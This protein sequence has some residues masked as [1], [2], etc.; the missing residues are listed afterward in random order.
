[1]SRYAAYIDESGNHDLVTEKNGASRYFIVL[2]ILVEETSLAELTTAVTAIKHEFFGPGEMK[3]SRVREDRRVRVLDALAPLPFRFYAVAVDKARIDRDSGLAFKTSFIKFANG[4]LYNAL[5]QNLTDLT[6]YADGH[7][8]AEFIE[9]FKKYL[10]TAHTPDLFSRPKIEIVDSRQEVLVQLADFL[11]GTAAKIYENKA[12]A[13]ARK[14]FLD[15]LGR[16]RIRIDEWPPRF[17][18]QYPAV[19]G[20]SDLDGQVRSIS[21]RAAAQFLSDFSDVEDLE[22]RIQHAFVSYL[23]FRAQFPLEEEFMSTPELIDHLGSLG[24]EEIDKHFLR[25]NV[26]S[27]LRDRGVLI[28]SSARGYKVPTTYSDVIGFAELVDGIVSPLLHRLRR[29]ND[30][31]SL[32]SGGAID[33]LGDVRFRKLRQILELDVRDERP[34]A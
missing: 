9:S 31:L 6:V 18:S 8:G 26:V 10:E 30:L 1:M 12:T 16:K 3:S 23:L 28:A 20:A 34:R 11:V 21:L 17:E 29:A 14:V 7:G 5:F 25:S 2:A 22:T 27:R 15:F 32:G 13:E 19:S 33:F 24:F 4:R